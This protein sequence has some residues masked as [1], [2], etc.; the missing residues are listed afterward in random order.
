MLTL[1]LLSR[2][3]GT[4]LSLGLRKQFPTSEYPYLL[5]RFDELPKILIS[6]YHE[7]SKSFNVPKNLFITKSTNRLRFSE[8]AAL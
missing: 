6:F 3:I 4:F 8:L 1:R 2:I 5:E 7:N